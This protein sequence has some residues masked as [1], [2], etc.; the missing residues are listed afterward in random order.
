ML[1]ASAKIPEREGASHYADCMGNCPTVS[2]RCLLYL[3]RISFFFS[4]P[5]VAE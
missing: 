3:P 4:V 5:G 1:I 2:H